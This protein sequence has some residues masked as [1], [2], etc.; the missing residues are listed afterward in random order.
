MKKKK[1]CPRAASEE[2]TKKQQ[3]RE[4]T[5]RKK[6]KEYLS[7]ILPIRGAVTALT[8]YEE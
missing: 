7:L 5:K 2:R 1:K 3:C 4:Q 8:I 6:I